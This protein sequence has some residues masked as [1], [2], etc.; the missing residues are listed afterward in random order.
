MKYE[1][2]EE[3]KRLICK[4]LQNFKTRKNECIYS[5]ITT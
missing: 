3:A 1:K 2:M 5:E 4:R